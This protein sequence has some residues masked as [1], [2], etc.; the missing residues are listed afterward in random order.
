M[1]NYCLY[2]NYLATSQF[3]RASD[4]SFIP[5]TAELLFIHGRVATGNQMA[6]ALNEHSSQIH[7]WSLPCN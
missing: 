1:S 2:V 6:A 5:C 3:Q 4:F 7:S